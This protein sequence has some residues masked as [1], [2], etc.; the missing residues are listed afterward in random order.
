MLWLLWELGITEKAKLLSYVNDATANRYTLFE[1][2]SC[3]VATLAAV[4]PYEPY[5]PFPHLA[6]HHMVH[7]ATQSSG[8]YLRKSCGVVGVCRAACACMFAHM[9]NMA[10]G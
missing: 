3:R 10:V 2:D 5:T 4:S 7:T 1:L 8:T 6:S 9:T